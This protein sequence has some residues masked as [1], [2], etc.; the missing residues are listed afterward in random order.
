[1]APSEQESNIFPL[2]QLYAMEVNVASEEEINDQQELLAINRRNLMLYLKQ[3]A[4]LGDTYVLPSVM[5][6]IY[7]ARAKIQ[8]IKQILRGMDVVIEDL[9]DDRD[10]EAPNDTDGSTLVVPVERQRL[11]EV[12]EQRF[13]N[14]DLRGLVFAL[15][16]DYDNL[17]GQTKSNKA[18]EL[19]LYCE[20]RLKLDALAAEIRR[21]RPDIA[22]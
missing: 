3:K 20:R 21:T 2:W 8:R 17:P 11:F 4:T 12:L 1:M 9:P 14:D 22:L 6:G 13:S 18:R 7:E 5:N 16:L 10:S 19:V 15:G